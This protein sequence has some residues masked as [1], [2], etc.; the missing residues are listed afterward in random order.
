MARTDNP[1]SM[2]PLASH[3]IMSTSDPWFDDQSQSVNQCRLSSIYERRPSLRT[4][5]TQR[6]QARSSDR[7]ILSRDGADQP[8]FVRG[9]LHAEIDLFQVEHPRS[10]AAT[11]V[12]SASSLK[13]STLPP[14]R[15]SRRHLA[16]PTIRGREHISPAPPPLHELLGRRLG[17]GSRTHGV[18]LPA[19]RRRELVSSGRSRWGFPAF[20][21]VM[22]GTVGRVLDRSVVEVAR[23]ARGL[24]KRPPLMS[25]VSPLRDGSPV[26]SLP[27][28][29]IATSTDAARRRWSSGEDRMGRGGG[30]GGWRK[31]E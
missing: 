25:P 28:G 2:A 12:W 19:L 18:G 24:E 3:T 6:W 11:N 21:A 5:M 31:K 26:H 15:S 30:G 1:L 7:P 14:P 23:S 22:C 20:S 13:K 29:A 4:E 8:Q 27:A 10:T 17:S 16:R 9:R